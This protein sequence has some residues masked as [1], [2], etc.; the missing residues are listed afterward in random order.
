MRGAS[1]LRCVA[2]VSLV[3]LVGCQDEYQPREQPVGYYY[4]AP[5]PTPM[6]LPMPMPPPAPMAVPAP[7]PPQV[8]VQEPLAEPIVGGF[9]DEL[10]PYG[11]WVPVG[12]YGR[13]WRP[14]NVDPTW[15][16]YTVG[17]WVY[18]DCGWTWMSEEPWGYSTYHYGRW[19]FDGRH[20]WVW[21]PGTVWAPAWVAWR[22]GGGYVGWA[23]L[24]PSVG[25][26]VNE[27]YTRSIPASQFYFVREREMIEPHIHRHV[28]DRRQN[29][30]I[31][32]TTTNITNITVV[33]NTVVNRSLPVEQVERATGRRI[34]RARIRQVNSADEARRSSDVAVYRPKAL[35]PVQ[36]RVPAPQ[37]RQQ[38]S[39]IRP[40][41]PQPPQQPQPNSQLQPQPQPKPQ[42]PRRVRPRLGAAAPVMAPAKGP[43]KAPAKVTKPQP[44]EVQRTKPGQVKPPEW[45]RPVASAPVKGPEFK[46]AERQRLA[47][48]AA[49]P[50]P[51]RNLQ[52]PAPAKPDDAQREAAQA[53]AEA[54]QRAI[55]K[56]DR[57]EKD[58]AADAPGQM[59]HDG[60]Q[61]GQVPQGR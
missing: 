33:N 42:Q 54:A 52:K 12:S 27:Y 55:A 19:F 25:V 23:P 39:P 6:P 37:R 28:V 21:V 48:P 57:V 17:H 60:S 49:A 32:N 10:S 45:Q 44:A 13:C 41:Q 56:Q 26:E 61:E 34:Q 22:S 24:G 15:R 16:P 51:G 18:A 58:D 31:I 36:Q 11:Q 50:A 47:A 29:V 2:V 1:L 5:A 46:P 43:A 3:M 9:Y 20:G 30:T 35:P 59:N 7:E 38:I 8:I 14:A 40:T 53:R 4:P